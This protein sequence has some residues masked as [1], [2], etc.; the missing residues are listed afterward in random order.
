MDS[1]LPKIYVLFLFESRPN[2]HDYKKSR[3]EPKWIIYTSSI[4]N[5]R[6]GQMFDIS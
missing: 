3:V 4:Y 2:A 1:L 6:F 5:G